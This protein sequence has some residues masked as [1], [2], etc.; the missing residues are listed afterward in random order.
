MGVFGRTSWSSRFNGLILILTILG[1]LLTDNSLKQL[2]PANSTGIAVARTTNIAS[3]IHGAAYL[4]FTW[5][6]IYGN[7]SC[8][9]WFYG[10]ARKRSVPDQQ[11]CTIQ[12]FRDSE[13]NV[14]SDK[15]VEWGDIAY[16]GA[17]RTRCKEHSR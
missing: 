15:Y 7:F 16:N 17:D 6:Y 2:F 14:V 12:R 13:I 3:R 5:S 10:N 4:C 9:A 8:S 1:L 11:S